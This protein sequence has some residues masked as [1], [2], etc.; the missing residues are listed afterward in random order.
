VNRGIIRHW[1]NGN[2][3]VFKELISSAELV[4]SQ[5][6][7]AGTDAPLNAGRQSSQNN[8]AQAHYNAGLGYS[9]L[10]DKVKARAEFTQALM[11][12]PDF[13]NAKIA[14]DQL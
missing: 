14:L 12:L 4:L 9:G 5:S 10:G 7:K 13:L 8:L 6:G 1:Q 11:I 3:I 2:D